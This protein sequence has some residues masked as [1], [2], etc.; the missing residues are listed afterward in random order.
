MNIKE[1]AIMWKMNCPA[2]RAYRWV[3]THFKNLD[4]K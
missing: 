2:P 3:A 4:T 1:Q